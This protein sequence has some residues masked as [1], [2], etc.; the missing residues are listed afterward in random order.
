MS[1]QYRSRV[2]A[3]I[4]ETAEGLIGA[5]REGRQG[6]VAGRGL[7][8]TDLS[9]AAGVAGGGARRNREVC[10]CQVYPNGTEP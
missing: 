8:S 5:G 2:L 10:L 1:R 7:S 3:S 4:H 9:L 6:G